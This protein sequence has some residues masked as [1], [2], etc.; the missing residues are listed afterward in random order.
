MGKVVLF[1]N[2]RKKGR[3]QE[4]KSTAEE[5]EKKEANARRQYYCLV[6]GEVR[7]LFFDRELIHVI[8]LTF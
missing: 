5:N 8:S 4:R 6:G 1:G 3:K 2:E 7:K